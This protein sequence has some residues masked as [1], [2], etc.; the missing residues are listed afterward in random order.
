MT[1][2]SENSRITYAGDGTTTAFTVNYYFLSNT[3]LTVI[4]TSSA[5]VQTTLVLNTDYTVTG[6]GVS[7]GGTVTCTTAPAAGST[8][9]IIRIPQY[10]QETDY[11]PNDPF[12]AESHERAL[13]KLTMLSQRL[14]DLVS[15]ALHIAD[16]DSTGAST[17]LPTPTANKILGWD[18]NGTAILNYDVQDFTSTIAG[19]TFTT[20][21]FSGNG[22]TTSFTLSQMP[23]SVSALE[24]FISG[25]RQKS[26][27]D[28][29]ISGTTLLF[30]SAPA[31]GAN[32]IFCRWGSA[33]IL[34]YDD[35]SLVNFIQSGT[36]A[37]TRSVQDKNCDWVNVRDFGATGNG[38]DN[39]YAALQAA[40]NTG[41][42][43][44]G[45]HG[46]VY[47]ITSGLTFPV[48]AWQ[49]MDLQFATIKPVGSFDAFTLIGSQ[50]AVRNTRFDSSSCTGTT[51]YAANAI[52]EFTFQD[53]VVQS[54]A[55]NGITMVDPYT[56]R[57]DR[58]SV[59]NAAA[60]SLLLYSA[61]PGIPV[62]SIWFDSC[63][64]NG[65]TYTGDVFALEAVAGVFV[66]NCSFQG[67]EGSLSNDI[68]I[69]GTSIA[70][71][72]GI[73]VEECYFETAINK[74]GNN[75]SV[76]GY[77][78]GNNA[79]GI[80]VKNNYFQTS[81]QQVNAGSNVASNLEISG[82]TFVGITGSPSYAVAASGSL[83]MNCHSNAGSLADLDRTF[84][85]GL[86]FGGGSTGMTFSSQTGQYQRIGNRITGEI[87][88]VLTAKGTS[89]GSAV[90]TNLPI[91][92]SS[93]IQQNLAYSPIY[94]GMAS[95]SG[96]VFGR[97]SAG[98]TGINLSTGGASAHTDVTE[99][100]F[101]NSTNLYL[102][103]SYDVD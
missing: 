78:A 80:K 79:L 17:L 88:L 82:N 68:S 46:D 86:T 91:A 49:E 93:S 33:A 18:Q 76:S 59:L 51:I 84:T 98:G 9:Q 38:V 15:R 28:Y 73:Y 53:V 7:S 1:V 70:G 96:G 6:A 103:F 41:K 87:K 42:R 100:M 30:S 4:S 56:G 22:S 90:V 8:L 97:I 40:I 65:S 81:K 62:N 45:R 77:S 31:S 29:N 72:S 64:F 99:A 24:V 19:G 52:Q 60:R 66:N 63:N 34:G 67:N 75:I 14:K 95:I 47:R 2:A 57:F 35:A 48:S 27:A 43:V 37:V 50:F 92:A 36:G 10:T 26:G 16:G 11:T 94:W 23:A 74:T 39:D 55:G 44:I 25:V 5:G 69:K 13:D 58:V 83:R 71:A 54:P 3:D 85:P 101:T 61:S 21:T 89:T 102:T 32:N 12:P 20:Q